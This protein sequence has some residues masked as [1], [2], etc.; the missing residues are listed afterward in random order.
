MTEVIYPNRRA[1]FLLSIAASLSLSL[2][3]F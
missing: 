3:C 2:D 1:L